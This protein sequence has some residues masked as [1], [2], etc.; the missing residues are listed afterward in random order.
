M[1][2]ASRRV[3]AY[4]HIRTDY[5]VIRRVRARGRVPAGGWPCV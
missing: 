3:R 2:H 4:P 1:I 5:A